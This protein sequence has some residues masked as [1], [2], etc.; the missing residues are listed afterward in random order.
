MHILKLHRS[1]QNMALPY[2]FPNAVYLSSVPLHSSLFTDFTSTHRP[3]LKISWSYPPWSSKDPPTISMAW[4][5]TLHGSFQTPKDLTAFMPA[6]T[7]S[8][9]KSWTAEQHLWSL[10]SCLVF[11]CDFSPFCLDS[12]FP[13]TQAWTLLKVTPDTSLLYQLVTFCNRGW[14]ILKISPMSSSEFLHFYHQMYVDINPSCHVIL[15][16]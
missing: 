2:P 4:I 15:E 7:Q 12:L 6:H 9:Q 5:P 11:S 16:H 13:V 3:F 14:H 10:P 8:Q 1:H